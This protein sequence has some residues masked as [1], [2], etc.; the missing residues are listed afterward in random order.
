M[1]PSIEGQRGSSGS[2]VPLVV[3][4]VFVISGVSAL[5]YQLV[6]QRSLMMIYGS[7]VES[8]AMVVSAFMV[9]LGLGSLAGGTISRWRGMP[10]VLLFA[11]AELLIG[12]YGVCSLRLFHWLGSYTL[13][14]GT[15]ETGLWSFTLVFIPTLFMGMTLPL[16]VAYRVNAIGNVGQSVSWLYFVNT[17]GAGIGAFAAV[18]LFLGHLGLSGSVMAAALLNLISAASIACVWAFRRNTA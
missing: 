6:W 3:H 8:C 15:L 13:R 17:L 10:L 2:M 1:T 7:N 4:A 16:L 9:G 14:A 12:L 11:A 18:Y 5:L